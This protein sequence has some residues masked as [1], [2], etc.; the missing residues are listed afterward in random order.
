MRSYLS[1]L[2]VNEEEFATK[3]LQEEGVAVIPGQ[4][5][6]DNGRGHIRLTFVT[7]PE[8]RIQT[9]VKRIADF[10]SAGIMVRTVQ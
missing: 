2:G 10:V 9:G 4:F 6:G 3:L 8:E 7:E 1:K 5:F